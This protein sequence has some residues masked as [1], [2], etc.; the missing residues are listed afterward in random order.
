MPVQ[1]YTVYIKSPTGAVEGS[2]A[3]ASDGCTDK[4]GCSTQHGF[5]GDTL[6]AQV[7]SRGRTP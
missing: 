6:Y 3:A 7:R 1:D 2:W 5:F 4:A